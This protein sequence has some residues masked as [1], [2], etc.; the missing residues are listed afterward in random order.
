MIEIRT[1]RTRD[2]KDI[3]REWLISLK[4]KRAR[5]KIDARLDRLAAGNFGDHKALRKGLY[6]LR[7]NWGPGFRVYY[8]LNG[9]TCVLLLCGGD[10]GSQRLDIRRALEF[11]EDFQGTRKED[12]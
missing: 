12:K 9:N 7:I 5:A 3:F 1:Y 2:G 6:E 4:D 11:L 8:T 10:K